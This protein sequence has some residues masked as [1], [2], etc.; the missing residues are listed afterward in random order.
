MNHSCIPSVEIKRTA[1]N[2]TEFCA[3]E[4]IKEGDELTIDY[5]NVTDEFGALAWGVDV[6]F[7][8]EQIQLE[9]VERFI[10]RQTKMKEKYHCFC[11]CKLCKRD[12]PLSHK[13][14]GR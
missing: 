7:L 9:I 6:H 5:L 3:L 1:N 13:I 8:P 12:L 11:S 14:S 2:I 4:D 10:E